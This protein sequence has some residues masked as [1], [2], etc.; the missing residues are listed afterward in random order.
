MAQARIFEDQ[1]QVE[2]REL[3]ELVHRAARAAGQ[4]FGDNS[5]AQSWDL[6]QLRA[7]VD[8][9][10]RLLQALRSRFPHQLLDS[11]RQSV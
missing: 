2:S 1:L 3:N 10:Q 11:E 6:I 4:Q 8:E 9:V 5:L 7:R